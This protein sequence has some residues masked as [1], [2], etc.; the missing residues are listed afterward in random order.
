M[1]FQKLKPL[2]LKIN[3]PHDWEF[4]ELKEIIKSH[5][6]GIFKNKEFYGKGENIVGVS[7]LYDNSKIDGQVFNLVSLEKDEKNNKILQEGDLIY[8]ES[9]LVRT[10]IGKTLYVTKDGAGTIFAWHTR[11]FKL[12]KMI[13]PIFIYYL[14]ESPFIRK[15][16]I[17][18]STTT[19]LTGITTK[20]YFGTR[21]PLPKK[22]EQQK[23]AS[24]LSN[25]D[26]LI[27]SYGEIIEKS[28]IVRTGIAKKLLSKGLSHK[29]FQKIKW[30]FGK[31]FDIPKEWTYE[32]LGTYVKIISGKY[33]AYS[34]FVSSGIPVLKIDNVMHG[35]IDWTKSTFVSDVFMKSHKEIILKERDI[36]LALNRPITHNLVKVSYLSKNDVPSFLYQRVGK[37]EFNSDHVVKNFFFIFLNSPG[38]K[39]ILSRILIGSDQPYVKTTELLKQQVA[40]PSDIKEQQKIADIIEAYDSKITALE[41]KKKNLLFIKKE[42]M[43]KLLTGQIRVAV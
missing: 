20:E 23:I 43:Q 7:N 34:D 16:L 10:G 8:G 11:R 18:R 22:P 37:F 41:L 17:A 12:M 33:F 21:I 1:S 42:L 25:F 6:S 29:K 31:T 38:F 4:I 13:I 26:K 40:F 32:N 19:A 39:S 9:S 27:E 15:S 28:K 30:Y 24:I 14:M 36:V 3:F 35:K 2:Y 5:N